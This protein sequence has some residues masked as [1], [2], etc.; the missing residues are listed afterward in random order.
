MFTGAKIE[1]NRHL[2]HADF[3]IRKWFQTKIRFLNVC[4]ILTKIHVLYV[5]VG[6][7]PRRFIWST[8]SDVQKTS[9]RLKIDKLAFAR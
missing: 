7:G 9:A 3:I 4:F 5:V 1:H 8:E 6:F 2:Y